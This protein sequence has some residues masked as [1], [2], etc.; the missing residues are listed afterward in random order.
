MP[1]RN[2]FCRRA[3]LLAVLTAA[4]WHACPGAVAASPEIRGTWITTTGN[5]DWTSANIGTTM[6]SLKQVGLNT[7][8]VEAWKNGSTNFNSP[9]LQ[10]FTGA[11]SLNPSLGGQIL[12]DDSR[13]AAAANGLVH[14]AWFEYGNMS[15]FLGNTGTATS[16][17]NALSRKLRDATWTVGTTSGTGW[18]LRDPNGNYTTGSNGFVWMNPLVPEVRNL[19]KGIVTDAINQF[20][21][22]IVQFDDHLAWPQA[23]GWDSYTAAVYKQET[24]NNLPGS[25]SDA[26]FAAWRRG[27]TQAFFAEVSDAAKAAKPS[28]IVSLAP[29]PITTASSSFNANWSQ[30]MTKSDEVLPQVYRSTISAFNTD[31]PGQITASG[32]NSDELGAGLRLLGTGA[33]TPWNDLQQQIERTRTDGALG[34]SIW[35]SN[36]ISNSG[37]NA[38]DNYNSQLTAYYD[39]PT[40]GIAANPH[41][42][43]TRWSGTGGNGGSGTWSQLASQWKDTSTIWV[44]SGTGIFDGVGG[45]VTIS[46]SVMAEAGLD[47]RTTGYTVTG[48]TLAFRGVFRAD[49]LVNVASGATTTLAALVTG[50]TGLTKSG[51]GTLAITGSAT[52]LTGGIQIDAGTLQVGA[53]GTVGSLNASTPI[54][55]ASG[56]TLAFNR[57]DTYGGNIANVISGS[58][59]VALLSGSLGLSGSHSY[60][61]GTL[62][63]GGTL[64]LAAGGAINHGAGNVT[65]GSTTGDVATLAL[66][67]GTITGS[68]GILGSGSGARGLA[69]I[70]GGTWTSGGSLVVGQSGSGSLVLTGSGVVRVGG[71]TGTITLAANPLSSGSLTVSSGLTSGTLQAATITGGSGAAL[72]AFQQS[73]T[74]VVQPVLSGSLAVTQS[75]GGTTILAGSNTYAGATTI[76]SGVLQVGA[77]GTT[78]FIGGGTVLNNATLA[79]NRSDDYGGPASANATRSITG[80]G[81]VQLLAGAL[82]LSGSSSY[83]GGTVIRGG[84]LSLTPTGAINHGTGNFVVGTLSGD[85]GTLALAAG[86]IT[87]SSGILG[88]A[89]GAV[90]VASLSGT[91]MWTSNGG[92]TVGSSGTGT[93]SLADTALV[94]VGGVAGTGTLT[95]AS[96]TGSRG[97][98][99]VGTGTTA[100]TLQAAVVRGGS[101]TAA[102]VFNHTSGSYAFSPQLT[103]TLSVTQAGPGRTLLSASSSYV[104]TT[105]VSS[106]TL[107]FTTRAALY[108]GGTASWTAA[109]LVTGS[110]ATL[111]LS[112][113]GSTGFTA[114]DVDRLDS[115]GTA[116]GGFRPGSILGLDTTNA[117]S[118]T[119]S[120]AN[121]IANPNGGANLLGLAKLGAGTLVLSGSNTFT[122]PTT[123][124]QGRLQLGNTGALSSSAVTV[125]A[126]ATLAVNPQVAAVVPALVNNGLVDVGL[127]GLTVTSGQTAAGLVAGIVAGRNG[128]TWD[129]ATGIT[130]TSAAGMTDRAVGWIDHG[131]GSFTVGFAAAGD[132]DMNGLVDLDD[133]IAFVNSG[134]YD[135]GLA[136]T[137]AQGDYDYSGIVDLDDV[138]AF[139]SGGLYDA[140]PYNSSLS[141]MSL[142]GLGDDPGLMNGINGGFA[143][144]PEPA[145]W[146]LAAVGAGIAAGWRRRRAVSSWACRRR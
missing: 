102:V 38:T 57:S 97:T 84:T 114:A 10:A 88:S 135:T 133:V 86:S 6:S 110:A 80:A 67:L 9:T 131:G 99:N 127:G 21:L 20:D 49:N 87:G 106:G 108:G 62:V 140:G 54:T 128:G 109:N 113:G 103:G 15:Q 34:H 130:S 48:G 112:V 117:A 144:V 5:D 32:T 24:G 72:V 42:Q 69:T 71:G 59:A 82:A 111:A 143:A 81:G 92:M 37:T 90:G 138:I 31:W 8:Y 126:G 98:L 18:L 68:N 60:A 36:G 107:Q 145:A 137:W 146:M 120:Y 43:S 89:A 63:R 3:A 85:V 73:G 61:G 142:S 70:S 139:V 40:N 58:G 19:I 12:L 104:G 50:S 17:F 118:G 44:S 52:G 115:L 121:A 1:T 91:S 94:R 116:T 33:S 129:G 64:A 136:A 53:S 141:G 30:W 46:G 74:Y 95:L 125:A 2:T 93:L 25:I 83:A 77:G 55:V 11:T 7:V 23:Y 45:T 78:G 4:V 14:G 16:G 100:G 123:V 122:G 56:G 124:A 51:A 39:V 27:K 26:T 13:K 41:F 28:V 105:T 119:F 101:G 96:G 29:S 22:Q 75:G 47:F 134:L 76:S 66:S 132:L 65:L 35:F 79:F